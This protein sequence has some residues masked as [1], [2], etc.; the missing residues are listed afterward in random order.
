[1]GELIS[2]CT[3]TVIGVYRLLE[4]E[5]QAETRLTTRWCSRWRR[6]IRDRPFRF[7]AGFSSA[8]DSARQFA[9]QYVQADAEGSS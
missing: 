2:E 3:G 1:V 9:G 6:G 5:R 7:L 8:G 4:A